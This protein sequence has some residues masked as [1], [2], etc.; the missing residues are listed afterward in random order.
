M[1][2]IQDTDTLARFCAACAHHPYVTVDTEFLRERTYY[3]QL[4][5][6]Q[7]AHPGR[8]PEGAVLIDTLADRLSLDPLL[9]LFRNREVVKVFHAARQDLEIFQ[10]DAGVIPKPFFDTQVAAMVCGYGDQVGYETLA[11][12]IAG[13]KIDKSSRFTDW[14]RRPL[15]DAQKSYALADVTHLRQI[16]EVLSARLTKSGRSAWVDEE[17][18]ILL[19]PETYRTDPA[20]A[21]MRV[22]TRSSSTKFLCALKELARFREIVARERNVPRNRVFKDDA[23]LELAAG[24]PH[25]PEDLSKSRLLTREARKG[26]IADGILAAVAASKNLSPAETPT[27]REMNGRKPG[28]EALADLLRVLLKARSEAEGVA[29]RLV[30]SSA[31]LDRIAGE[32]APDVPALHGWRNDVFGRDA[33]RLKRGEIALSASGADVKVVAIG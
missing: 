14:S 3:A 31:D 21:W 32:D 5:L 10:V 33:M 7:L 28:S 25:T 27:P 1:T 20:D 16:Y 17:L 9:D 24:R 11:R 6:V 22:K 2:L 13:A 15:T 18:A 29:Q 26:D 12:Q 4:C 19:D 8:G 30:A 23:L